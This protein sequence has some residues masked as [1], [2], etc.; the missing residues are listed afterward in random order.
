MREPNFDRFRTA[1]LRRG[2]PD[3][4]PLGDISVHPILKEGILGRPIQTLEDEVAFWLAAGY[5]YIPLEQ[6]LQLTDVIRKES[7][8]QM[9]A[10]Y[11]VDTAERQIRHWATEGKGLI[12][13]R[14]ELEAFSWPDPDALD[15]SA[16]ER[17]GFLLPPNVRA[18]A[19]LGKIFTCVWW[20]MGFEGMSLALADDPD[21][22]PTVFEK[23]GKF[24]FRVFENMLR[25][26]SIGVIWHADDIAYS[27]ALL[28]SP[29]IL[30]AH[31][32]PRYKEM[33]RIAHERG[34][35]AVYHS[36]GALQQVMEDIIDCQ[37]DG[38]NP[39]EPKAMDINEVKRKYGARI[40]LLGNIDLG[41]TL[42]RGTPEEV[43]AEVRQRIHDLAPGGGYA[44]ASSNSVP[45]YV[46]LAN[47]NALRQA[48][49]EYG[50]YPISV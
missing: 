8:H 35:L 25:F 21:L 5:D 20:L 18:I 13:T 39:I 15:Y 47:Y 41:Y 36:D 1:L 45:E 28:V 37:F 38:L 9:E 24:Q 7:M 43:K 12:T 16:F 22:V 49:F 23:V 46:P 14:A 27:T 3:C 19:I 30:R 17:I 4:V 11:A 40:S 26:D 10:Q 50:C 42:T 44:V 33:N 6:G 32:F 34:V 48:A 29:R 31:L 2:E